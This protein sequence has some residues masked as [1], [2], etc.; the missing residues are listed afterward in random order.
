MP[1]LRGYIKNAVAGEFKTRI[2][3]PYCGT[4]HDAVLNTLRGPQTILCYPENRGCDEYFVVNLVI[5]IAEV[6][7]FKLEKQGN[8]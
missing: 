1:M 8:G 6:E 3:C 2:T 4:E 5:M 7:Y